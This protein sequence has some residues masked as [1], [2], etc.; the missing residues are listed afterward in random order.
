MTKES[1]LLNLYIFEEGN[2]FTKETLDLS[3]ERF[4]DNFGNE[5]NLNRI[6]AWGGARETGRSTYSFKVDKIDPE[7]P[8]SIETTSEIVK[9]YPEKAGF[10]LTAETEEYTHIIDISTK[11]LSYSLT[12][13]EKPTFSEASANSNSF[14]LEDKIFH[15]ASTKNQMTFSVKSLDGKKELK[16]V[17]VEKGEEISFKNT[18]VIQENG[19][20]SKYREMEKTSKFLRRLEREDIGIAVTK[21]NDHYIITMGSKSEIHRG[22]APMMMPGFGFPVGAAGAFTV[23]FNPTFFAYGSYSST[24]AT[25]IECLFDQDLNHKKGEIPKN[26]FDKIQEVADKI[27]NKDAETVF[28]FNKSYIWGYYNKKQD[29][30]ILFK[31]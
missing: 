5:Q 25:R 23:T 1:S 16:S 10:K 11:D 4:I 17:T 24:K 13:I 15:I 18:P 19:T 30:Y 31:F 14:I 22:G 8:N 12:S 6:M 7:S 27:N 20:Y 28:K 21:H 29:E 3:Q 26:V 9:M 2:A